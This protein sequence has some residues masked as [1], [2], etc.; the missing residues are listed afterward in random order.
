MFCHNCGQKLDNSAIYC[1]Q[2][3][4]KV[5][6]EDAT[7]FFNESDALFQY[8]ELEYELEDINDE[9]STLP[10]N[11]AYLNR[12]KQSRD[13]KFNQLQQIRDIMVKEKKDYDD[14]LKV[15]FSS[16]KA[17]L[18]GDLDEKKRLEEAEYL[19]ALANFQYIEKEYQKLE[20]EVTNFENEINRI[21]GLKS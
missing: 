5:G 3:G 6:K 4:I 12:L 19:K 16:I 18:R 20:T 21:N 1:E 7:K 2:C 10:S 14:L 9:V 15:S 8:H 13:Q 17:R 11:K